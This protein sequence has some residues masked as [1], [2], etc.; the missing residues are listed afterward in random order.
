MTN[1]A[2]RKLFCNTK[3]RKLRTK[4]KRD[5]CF[6]IHYGYKNN[7]KNDIVNGKANCI[8]YAKVYAG[9][10]DFAFNHC[11]CYMR[12]A[13]SMKHHRAPQICK[14]ANFKN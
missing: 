12:R 13:H 4:I 10:C 8:G 14:I 11:H 3:V 2:K 7:S 6:S 1:V 5:L 9:I